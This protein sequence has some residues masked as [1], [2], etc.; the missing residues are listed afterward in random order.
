MRD[1]VYRAAYVLHVI[2]AI[3]VAIIAA[4]ICVDVFART[5]FDRPFIGVP[6]IAAV[7]MLIMTYSQLPWAILHGRLLRV[8]FVL[9]ALPKKLRPAADVLGFGGGLIVLGLLAWTGIHPMIVSFSSGEYYGNPVFSIPAWP[10]RIIVEFL[11]AF[12]TLVCLYIVIEALRG[13]NPIEEPTS[14]EG[15]E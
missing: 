10:V 13:R 9:A 3:T 14:L 15:A 4:V 5:V 6:D 11:W 12:A 8:E 2:G 7:L 1:L